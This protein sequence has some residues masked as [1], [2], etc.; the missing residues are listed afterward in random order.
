MWFTINYFITYNAVSTVLNWTYSLFWAVVE[1][2]IVEPTLSWSLEIY[3]KH[4]ELT[5]M[6][7]Q[8]I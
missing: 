7:Y 1:H 4:F 8:A 2:L 3:F 5:I 6:D